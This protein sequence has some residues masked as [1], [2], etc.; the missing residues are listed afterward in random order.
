MTN[1]MELR[2]EEAWQMLLDKGLKRFTDVFTADGVHLGG[3][4][5]IHFRP[6]E[7]VDPGV[8]LWAAYLEIFADELGEHIFVPTDFVDEYDPEANKVVLI[9]DE[10]VVEHETWSNIPDFVARK[11]SAVEELP[12]PEGYPAA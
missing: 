12:Y 3:A 1:L 6:E 2:D 4:I 8:K 7:E 9:V 10:K 11:L 5:R